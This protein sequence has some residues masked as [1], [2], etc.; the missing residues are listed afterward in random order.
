[1]PTLLWF[2]RE[3]KYSFSVTEYAD[4]VCIINARAHTHERIA[5]TPTSF[6]R[7]FGWRMHTHTHTLYVCLF[8]FLFPSLFISLSISETNSCVEY[9]Y[10]RERCVHVGKSLLFFYPSCF[11]HLLFFS[12]SCYYSSISLLLS[13]RKISTENARKRKSR[14]LRGEEEEEKKTSFSLEIGY[15]ISFFLSFFHPFST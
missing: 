6:L 1:M 13:S 9:D 15:V 3:E 4:N 2:F 10:E 7:F 11:L 5:I 8:P 14:V 12:F